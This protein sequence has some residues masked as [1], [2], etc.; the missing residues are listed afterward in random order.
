MKAKLLIMI[1]MLVLFTGCLSEDSFQAFTT[2]MEIL[3]IADESISYYLTY[4]LANTTLTVSANKG[5]RIINV[6]SAVNCLPFD[7]LNIYDDNNL[8]Q[9]LIESVT[10]NSITI[11]QEL[12]DDWNLSNTIVECAEWDLSTSDGSITPVSFIA[13]P[14]SNVTWHITSTVFTCLDNTVMDSAKFCGIPALSNGIIGRLVDGTQKSLF[15]INNNIGFRQRG[16]T[17]DDI[18]RAP[19]GVYGS[20]FELV[21][22]VKYGTIIETIGH[23]N[24]TWEALNQDDLTGISEVSITVQGHIER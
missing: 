24:E 10:A 8:F 20:F 7:A 1:C 5:D 17:W 19:A 12:D 15:L 2:K 16:F 18:D 23:N 11:K 3:E 6:S 9:S 4:Q 22:P 13:K 14:P 21:F